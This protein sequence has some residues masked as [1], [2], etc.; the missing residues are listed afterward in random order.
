[1]PTHAPYRNP[2][3]EFGLW[4]IW[5]AARYTAWVVPP[6]A[7]LGRLLGRLVGGAASWVAAHTV[8]TGRRLWEWAADVRRAVI[9]GEFTALQVFVGAVLVGLAVWILF[10]AVTT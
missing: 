4:I 8:R 5:T 9:P 3:G 10:A 6:T 2:I 1:M 7:A